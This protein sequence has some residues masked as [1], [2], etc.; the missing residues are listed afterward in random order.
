MI[1]RILK[2]VVLIIVI[3]FIAYKAISRELYLE[4]PFIANKIKLIRYYAC[5]LAICA[6]GCGSEEVKRI[7]LEK[8][9]LGRCTKWCQQD[10]CEEQFGVY[11]G[12][13]CGREYK[14]NVSL[15]SPVKLKGCRNTGEWAEG[16]EYGWRVITEAFEIAGR[17]N[18]TEK[19]PVLN[20]HPF[21]SEDEWNNMGPGMEGYKYIMEK[22]H[23]DSCKI[24]K[25]WGG[26]VGLYSCYWKRCGAFGRQTFVHTSIAPGTLH[27]I[28]E[29]DVRLYGSGI[30]K[31]EEYGTWHV[32][33]NSHGIGAIL[34]TPRDAIEWECF[35]HPSECQE[36]YYQCKFKGK[37]SMYTIVPCI[38]PAKILAIYP[39]RECYEDGSEE[40]ENVIK[41]A[42]FVCPDVV[43]EPA[44]QPWLGYFAFWPEKD[45]IKI[46]IGQSR[47]IKLFIEN[48]LGFK[49]TFHMFVKT[50]P[51]VTCS[52]SAYNITLNDGEKDEITLSCT[53]EKVDTA[54][55]VEVIA[56]TSYETHWVTI[57]IKPGNFKVYFDVESKEE[58][59]EISSREGGDFKVVLENHLGEDAD[60]T[61]RLTTETNDSSYNDAINCTFSGNVKEI[62]VSLP[63]NES[64]DF[65]VEC[66]PTKDAEGRYYNLTVKATYHG[67]NQDVTRKDM[68][69]VYVLE[70]CYAEDFDVKFFKANH[71]PGTC[72]SL[73]LT[74]IPA[75]SG[76]CVQVDNF[77]GCE[78]KSIKMSIAPVTDDGEVLQKQDL[79]IK[80]EVEG[81]DLHIIGDDEQPFIAGNPGSY[82]LFVNLSGVEKSFDLNITPGIPPTST[83]LSCSEEEECVY[84]SGVEDCCP[85]FGKYAH[86]CSKCVDLGACMNPFDDANRACEKEFDPQEC[87]LRGKEKC[88]RFSNICC[89]NDEN[90]YSNG[91]PSD[92]HIPCLSVDNS[93]ENEKSSIWSYEG[94]DNSKNVLVL[95]RESATFKHYHCENNDDC[96]GDISA[97]SSAKCKEIEVG[98]EGEKEKFCVLTSDDNYYM[99]WLYMK[100]SYL[101]R[102]IYGIRIN[103]NELLWVDENC[104]DELSFK[105][106][107]FI[108]NSSGWFYV[109]ELVGL[110]IG[111]YERQTA[112]LTPRN[113]WVWKNVDAILIGLVNNEIRTTCINALPEFR[114]DDADVD[115]I[116]L[117]TKSYHTDN[118][119]VPFCTEGDES[120]YHRIVDDG[121]RCYW[122][123]DC[124][125]SGGGWSAVR[126][127]SSIILPLHNYGATGICYCLIS[128]TCD[129]GYC[130]FTQ[131][132]KTYCY[133][134]VKCAHGG[135]WPDGLEECEDGEVCTWKG[136]VS[137]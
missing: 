3:V 32:E 57:S 90:K 42:E 8:D 49:D 87:Y 73:E 107:V 127:N 105:F 126:M 17:L 6:R 81:N 10:I 58:V 61:L 22:G 31:A 124:H 120:P 66:R 118:G 50:V 112:Y 135:W 29:S 110:W 14:I 130:E 94:V 13:L 23:T 35:T 102:A 95:D 39:D 55:G 131:G 114:S 82:K 104:R 101:G 4:N 44:D 128:E 121:T 7:C 119:Y 86:L 67:K 47:S 18:R 132:D 125:K 74:E 68:I 75:G 103:L 98:P 78:G 65:M 16:M 84:S 72:S 40:K 79:N 117:L 80:E 113:N 26:C 59:Q 48:H 51:A 33:V 106:R 134:G 122:D 46:P 37:I 2:Y 30:A 92:V 41:S 38:A 9:I 116:G 45:E 69:R 123:V 27:L 53:P 52:L 96:R 108:H 99:S 64:S 34:M 19:F 85:P 62:E 111:P 97:L 83:C 11:R 115:Y 5:S 24:G 133:Y 28:N 12:R 36:G 88:A 54:Y 63:D 129:E 109:G 20:N 93:T 25:H 100:V 1:F 71:D 136:C 15:E 43:F 21:G 137:S 76:F 70:E 89:L 77:E 91:P 60:F 56:T